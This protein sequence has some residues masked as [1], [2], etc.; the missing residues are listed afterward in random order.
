MEN[1]RIIVI[2]DDLEIRKVYNAV[3]C[4]EQYDSDSALQQMKKLL[5]TH[6]KGHAAEKIR[7]DLTFASQGQEGFELV[8]KALGNDAPFSVAFIDV[9]MPPGWNG[10]ETATR[11]RQIDPRIEIVIVTAYSDHTMEE[12]VRC[13]GTPEK[14]LFL[15]KPFDPEE[16]MQMALSLSEKWNLA[17]REDETQKA[18]AKSEERFRDLIETTNDMVW[19]TD[20]KGYFTYCSPVCENIYGFPPEEMKGKSLFDMIS[21]SVAADEFKGFFTQ[22]A[23]DASAFHSVE[24]PVLHKDGQLIYIETSGA[25]VIGIDGKT[26]EFRGIDRDITERKH[27]ESERLKLEAQYRQSQKLEAIGTLAGGIAHDFNN[28]LSGIIGYTE[29]VASQMP[30]GSSEKDMLFQVLEASGRASALV[31]QILTFS[32]QTEQEIRPIN[33]QPI[34]KE[35]LKLLRATIPS[36]I[37][38]RQSINTTSDTVMADPTRIHQLVMNLCTNAAHA[39]EVSG[40]SLLLGLDAIEITEDL[41]K[42]YPDLNSGPYIRL[43]VRDTGAG[44]EPEIIE[45]IFDPFFTTKKDGKGT[46]LGLAV[47]HGIVKSYGGKIYV[48]SDR[49]GTLFNILLP[50]VIDASVGEEKN[51]PA[52]PPTG[53]EHILFVDDED[54]LVDIGTKILTNLGYQVTTT[55]SS[56]EALKIFTDAPD[57]FDILI[58]DMTMP[59]MT[60]DQLAKK[61]L[62][63]RPEIPIILCSGFSES[64]SPDRSLSMGIRTFLRKPVPMRELA[65]TIRNVLDT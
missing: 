50:R 20:A 27:F 37:E 3:L 13:V 17:K 31:K 63:I 2:D 29:L 38:I 10:K 42:Q 34:I 18:L 51:V 22:C 55:T 62:A 16:L 54:C 8:Q 30:K 19:E 32:R 56:V 11:I 15:R 36:T 49:N 58:T 64:M 21:S 26:T 52:T 61:I 33:I 1:R 40:G 7:F 47:V 39:M 14:L 35:V 12:I 46:G 9:R 43:M 48:N 4:P 6:Q 59:K 23:D 53:T 24:R 28:I 65:A 44:I 5:S 45:K 25:P 60:G 41:V 57:D